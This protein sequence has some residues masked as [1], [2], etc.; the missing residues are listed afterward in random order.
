VD[1]W[2][3]GWDKQLQRDREWARWAL[4]QWSAFPARGQRPLVLVGPAIW[5]QGGFLDGAAKLAYLSGDW[6]LPPSVPTAVLATARANMR[7]GATR[8]RDGPPLE[9]HTA[10]RTSARF[11]TDR[12]PLNL[13]AWQLHSDQAKGPIWVLDPELASGAW[14]PAL[15][16]S[17]PTFIHPPHGQT[18]QATTVGSEGTRLR[19]SFGG[20][21]PRC[22]EYLSAEVLESERAVV[23]LPEAH[24]IGPPGFRTWKG[25]T[26]D[27]VAELG[28]PLGDRV[29]VDVDA[30][31][32]AV[33]SL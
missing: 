15:V 17:D 19:V 20:G 22:V 24:D 3:E 18:F 11:E 26:R 1:G 28:R 29:L 2:Q 9:I 14:A 23:V 8:R 4:Q 27:V 12:G 13:S 16:V 31:P 6:Q 30:S 33:L 21:S 25:Y 10:H 32:V 7:G 5:S